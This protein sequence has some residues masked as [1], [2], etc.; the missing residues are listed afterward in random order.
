MSRSFLLLLLVAG[1]GASV[2]AQAADADTLKRGKMLFLQCRACHETT[3]EA[4]PRIGPT[5]YG[6]IGAK[7]AAVPGF[8]Y[9]AALRSSKLTW[10]RATLDQWLASP[11]KLVPGNT[12]AFAGM[13]KPED[14]A[15]L[16]DWLA[17]ETTVKK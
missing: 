16:I 1:F 15:A 12:M 2:A 17:A 6:L 5:L 14:R 9:S 8:N 4:S 13:S 10:D 11:A 7:A 3:K